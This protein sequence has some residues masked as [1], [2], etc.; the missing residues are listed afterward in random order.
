MPLVE[1]RVAFCILAVMKKISFLV[2]LLLATLS[3]FASID[4]LLVYSK[5]MNKSIKVIVIKPAN[6]AAKDS[7]PVVYLLHGHSANYRQWLDEA[8][9]IVQQSKDMQAILVL[10]DGGYNSWYFDSPIN[11]SIQYETFIVKELIPFIDAAYATKAN[12]N[13]RAI[14]G[15]SMGGH[16]AFYLAMRNQAVFGNA[17]SICGGLDLRPF[18]NNWQLNKVLGDLSTQPENWEKNTVINLI[19][20]ID[21]SKLNLIFDC[22]I[23][24]FFLGVN[25]AMHQKLLQ[26]KIPHDYT[27]RPGSHNT[28]YWSNSIHYQL[29]YFQHQFSKN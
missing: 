20:S 8:P 10:P 12:R 24:D 19:D 17:G 22:G 26:K 1:I 14:T 5:H 27:E 18:P 7:L 6:A 2:F 25:R 16:G 3:S 11:P 29:M 4:T 28:A 15:L 23:A 13:F 9:S 21:V